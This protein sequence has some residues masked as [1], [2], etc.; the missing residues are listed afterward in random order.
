M[1]RVLDIAVVCVRVRIV[2]KLCRKWALLVVDNGSGKFMAFFAGY[3]FHAVFV[4]SAGS[5]VMPGIMVGMLISRRRDSTDV[6][7]GLVVIAVVVMQRKVP[8]DI[9]SSPWRRW[10]VPHIVLIENVVVFLVVNRDRYQGCLR[11]P[12]RLHSCSSWWVLRLPLVA[13]CLARQWI[14]VHVQLWVAFGRIS[15]IFF[16]KG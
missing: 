14:H 11:R 7:L 10:E 1:I 4:L 2:Q 16:V 13:Q 12:W 8:C 15:S 9:S 5:P 3:A 6:V